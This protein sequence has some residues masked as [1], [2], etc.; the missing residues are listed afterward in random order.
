MIKTEFTNRF[1]ITSG[2]RGWARYYANAGAKF[3][4]IGNLTRDHVNLRLGDMQFVAPPTGAE[5]DRTQLAEGDVLC[6]ITADL[7][8]IG[9][10]PCDFGPAYINQH[11]ALIRPR[12][13]DLVPGWLANFLAGERMQNWIRSINESG[14]KAGLNLP[15]I[16]ALPV[17]MPRASEQ[18]KI[19]DI[20]SLCDRQVA[21]TSDQ[22]GKLHRKKVGLLQ[23]LL[24]GRVPVTSLLP[25][26]PQ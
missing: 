5:G 16:K 4:R 21:E 1:S 26:P 22:V 19:A 17:T 18:R 2:P 24:T 14:A 7:G 25:N 10:I 23:D 20:L 13:D 11:I 12:P 6:S 8:M 9:L 3:I 15:T